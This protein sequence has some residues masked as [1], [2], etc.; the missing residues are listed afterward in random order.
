VQY[1]TDAL[2]RYPNIDVTSTTEVH[3]QLVAMGLAQD[4]HNSG[5]SDAVLQAK[6]E[7]AAHAG[8]TLDAGDLLPSSVGLAVIALSVFMNRDLSLRQKGTAFG[9]RSAKAGASSAMG[10][11]AMAATQTWWLGL[12]AGVGSGW[13]ATQGHGKREQYEA[14]KS[15]LKVMRQRAP[16]LIGRTELKLLDTPASRRP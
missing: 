1:V 14:L 7:A 8:S 5:V 12:I 9:S 3:G 4:V 15:A 13:L 2:Y 16:L 6:V 11:L 10:K